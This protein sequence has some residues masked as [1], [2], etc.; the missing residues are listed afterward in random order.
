MV[1]TDLYRI[2]L[3]LA[4]LWILLTFITGGLTGLNFKF[5]REDWLGGYSGLRRRMYRLGHVSLF[6]LGIVNLAFY[7]TVRE[8]GTTGLAL[9]GA[10]VGFVLGALTMPSCCYLMAHFPA[11][12]GLF[13]VPSLSLILAGILTVWGLL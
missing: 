13:Y 9:Q 4:W 12:K 10:S 6:A 1:G 5:F 2:N 8:I 7:F 3:L 11:L